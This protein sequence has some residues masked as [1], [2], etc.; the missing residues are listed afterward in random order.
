MSL[1]TCN[2][3]LCFLVF[4]LDRRLLPFVFSIQPMFN[5]FCQARQVQ[6]RC[7]EQRRCMSRRV[8]LSDRWRAHQ[9]ARSRRFDTEAQH[10]KYNQWKFSVFV[11]V[12]AV[13]NSEFLYYPWLSVNPCC[14]QTFTSSLMRWARRP[15]R[16]TPLRAKTTASM[17]KSKT[18]AIC[19]A[20]WG[21]FWWI[22][23][24]WKSIV[25]LWFGIVELFLFLF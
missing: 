5:G 18:A 11:V 9:H 13:F 21:Q 2:H 10:T 15:T 23:I 7:A 8:S 12:F 6:K 1:L 24:E 19:A 17:R 4:Y 16:K 14:L 22:G 25:F 20:K 3:G